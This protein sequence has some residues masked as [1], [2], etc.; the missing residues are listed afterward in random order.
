[1]YVLNEIILLINE[2]LSENIQNY[3]TKN[4]TKLAQNY[5]KI[6]EIDKNNTVY[7]INIC[8]IFILINRRFVYK[9]IK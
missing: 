2:I 6:R 3:T 5:T 1:M 9:D 4:E 7:V 8:T